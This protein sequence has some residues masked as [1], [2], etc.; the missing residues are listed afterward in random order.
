MK[1][2][3]DTLSFLGLMV[4]ENAPD[5][6]NFSLFYLIVLCFILINII[7]ISIYLLTIYILSNPKILSYIPEEYSNIHKLLQFYKNIRVLYIIYEVILLLIS[8]IIL[9]SLSYGIVSFYIH[10]K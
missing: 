9:I 5:I 7:N 8:L 10:I 6:V 3:N 1:F 2:I 4:D